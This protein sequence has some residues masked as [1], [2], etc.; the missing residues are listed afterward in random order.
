MAYG[1]INQT[2]V[3]EDLAFLEGN[4]SVPT[5]GIDDWKRFIQRTLDET[6][7]QY[8]WDFAKTLA[9]VAVT[10]GVATLASGAMAEGILD[11][12][13]V[14]SGTSDDL[15]FIEIPYN[16][17]D[18]Y[19]AA[20]YR[21]W[22]TGHTPNPVLNTVAT[23]SPLLVQYM[24]LPPQINASVSAP[25]PDSMIIALGAQRYV[26]KAEN[27]LADISQEEANFQQKVENLWSQYNR[28]RPRKARRFSQNI[29]TGQVGGD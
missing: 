13:Y 21:Y 17:R 1:A 24:S 23:D 6:W 7:I 25:F 27:P 26:R 14:N 9:T 4:Q 18:S 5:S 2:D 19:S 12:R 15:Q 10:N 11:V 28:A 8:P 22:L 29:R 3:L 16:E 20:D